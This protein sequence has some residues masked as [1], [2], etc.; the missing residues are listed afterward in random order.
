MHGLS[1]RMDFVDAN[2]RASCT[3]G[4]NSRTVMMVANQT[5]PHDVVPVFQIHVQGGH[6]PDLDQYLVQPTKQAWG[7]GTSTVLRFTTPPQPFLGDIKETFS[8]KL[9]AR[10]GAGNISNTSFDFQYHQHS[11]G[12]EARDGQ[13]WGSLYQTQ[14]NNNYQ[15]RKC[16]FCS[17]ILD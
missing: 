11:R 10:D 6:R 5:I 16:L 13:R 17:E 1:S 12:G 4:G 7:W 3:A 9:T 8:I 14:S 2:P 15:I